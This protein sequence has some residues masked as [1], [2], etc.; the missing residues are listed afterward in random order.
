MLEYEKLN[1]AR[2][3]SICHFKNNYFK[4]EYYMN[5]F[6]KVKKFFYRR[7]LVRNNFFEGVDFD[8][9]DRKIKNAILNWAYNLQWCKGITIEKLAYLLDK[10]EGITFPIRIEDFD[11]YGCIDLRILDA[12]G[13]RY[14][15]KLYKNVYERLTTYIIHKRTE[16][17][18]ITFEYNIR[19]DS[20]ILKKKYI[21]PVKADGTNETYAII[22]EYNGITTVTLDKDNDPHKISISYNQQ[23]N[24][25]EKEICEYLFSL[26][27]EKPINNV[28]TNFVDIIRMFESN[29]VTEE[30]LLA[31]KSTREDE[32]LSEITMTNNVVTKYSCTVEESES[33]TCFYKHS[34][35]EKMKDF[36]SKYKQ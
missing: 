23:L 17:F 35:K 16:K 10:F 18:K 13:K 34:I 28:Y 12:N 29:N 5:I 3:T 24:R 20:I 8:G 15:M 26:V 19:K 14:S 1:S 25:F 27:F 22:I 7:K 2:S 36:I 32:T 21:L 33:K 9:K 30:Y 4:E 31:I 11:R 6:R